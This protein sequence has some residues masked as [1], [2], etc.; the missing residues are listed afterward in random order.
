M[1]VL[2]HAGDALVAFLPRYDF[3]A[4]LHDEGVLGD[5]D[6]R[7]QPIAAGAS[8]LL[9]SRS[10]Q[11]P[12]E[13]HIKDLGGLL[14]IGQGERLPL[15]ERQIDAFPTVRAQLLGA[16]VQ[17]QTALGISVSQR[18]LHKR[19]PIDAVLVAARLPGALANGR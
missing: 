6:Q 12:A 17:H 14:A 4:V 3:A 18:P 11:L 13:T 9:V 1:P 5:I 16:Q 10:T 8:L 19:E 7:S 2:V 15:V